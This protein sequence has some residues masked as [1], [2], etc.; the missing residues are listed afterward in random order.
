MRLGIGEYNPP[1]SSATR[2]DATE[3]F[4]FALFRLVP[5]FGDD[6]TAR[7]DSLPTA[8]RRDSHI[9][10]V[11]EEWMNEH[12][13]PLHLVC[14][15]LDGFS[16]YGSDLPRSAKGGMRNWGGPIAQDWY[17]G[18]YEGRHDGFRI[19]DTPSET[20]SGDENAAF[21][22][23]SGPFTFSHPGDNLAASTIKEL[24]SE[25][26]YKFDQEL[27]RWSAAVRLTALRRGWTPIASKRRRSR[28]LPA[29]GGKP[30]TRRRHSDRTHFRWL[31][32]FQVLGHTLRTIARDAGVT[33]QSVAQAVRTTASLVGLVRRTAGKPGRPRNATARTQK[34]RSVLAVPT[35]T[36]KKLRKPTR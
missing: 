25:I 15:G 34:A 33:E 2:S 18:I 21:T 19:S 12:H 6:L 29:Q 22:C 7:L 32:R 5:N 26:R 27:V 35:R 20:A 3:Q 28:S 11:I 31:V 23:P 36:A 14:D 30:A 1:A 10:D 17:A 13:L 9:R 24:E 8:T 16:F 4:L